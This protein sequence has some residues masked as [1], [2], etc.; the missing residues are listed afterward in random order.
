M[1][2]IPCSD[3]N[4]W[5]ESLKEYQRTTIKELVSIHG[6]EGAARAWLTAQGSSDISP[7]GATQNI[8]LFWNKLNEEFRKFICDDTAYVKEKEELGKHAELTKPLLISAIS[9][10][11][12]ATIGYAATFIAPAVAILLYLV[13]KM[14]INAYC[15]MQPENHT[16]PI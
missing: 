13:G 14:A 8:S 6:E 16:P 7:F 3:L 2:T 1:I 15:N 5:T 10:A 12:G 11:I 4:S 9:S